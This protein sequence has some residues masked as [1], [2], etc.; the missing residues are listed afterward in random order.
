MEKNKTDYFLSQIIGHFDLMQSKGITNGNIVNTE[1]N[2]HPPWNS[3]KYYSNQSG[4]C[5][6]EFKV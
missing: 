1:G 5:W 4:R 3:T 2:I 6:D